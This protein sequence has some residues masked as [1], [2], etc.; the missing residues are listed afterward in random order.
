MAARSRALFEAENVNREVFADG[1]MLMN[2]N[3]RM[4]AGLDSGFAFIRGCWPDSVVGHI[5][6]LRV[7]C[8]KILRVLARQAG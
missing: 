7:L 6:I 4:A 3:L 1:Q 5:P 8:R 2:A